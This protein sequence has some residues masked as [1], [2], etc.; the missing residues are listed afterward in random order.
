MLDDDR[1]ATVDDADRDRANRTDGA[2]GDRSERDVDVAVGELAID[3]TADL[4]ELDAEAAGDERD[5]RA[6]TPWG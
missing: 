6:A 5:R 2:R 1:L 4:V 3:T